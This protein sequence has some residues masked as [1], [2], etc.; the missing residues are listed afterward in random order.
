[1]ALPVPGPGRPRGSRNKRHLAVEAKLAELGCDP[2]TA[3]ALLAMDEAVA[4]ELR[5]KLYCDLAGY[6]APKLKAVGNKLP[7][8]LELPPLAG[9]TDAVAASAALLAAV[10]AG[11]IA[12]GEAREVGRLLELHL[13]TIEQHEFDARLAAL[14]ARP[15]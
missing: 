3:M 9:S 12:P 2:I 11:A 7:G 14:E 10:A 1:M 6:V 15:R 8:G 5:I 4:I 13:R